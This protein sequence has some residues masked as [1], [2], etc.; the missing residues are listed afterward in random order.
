LKR[1]C[2]QQALRF[3]KLDTV[4]PPLRFHFPAYELT[5]GT[6]QT[7]FRFRREL[8]CELPVLGVDKRRGLRSVQ[9]CKLCIL[10][11]IWMV[12]RDTPSGNLSKVRPVVVFLDSLSFQ[13]DEFR[14]TQ[15]TFLCSFVEAPGGFV[16]FIVEEKY[17]FPRIPENS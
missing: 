4:F 2:H 17:I 12:E 6:P 11:T 10:Y 9:L 7:F 8:L 13:I 14:Q 5:R 15:I 1:L 3:V 16:Q